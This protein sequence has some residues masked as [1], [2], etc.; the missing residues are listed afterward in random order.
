MGND[1]TDSPKKKK[2]VSGKTA[3]LLTAI[4]RLSKPRPN[5]EYI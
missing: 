3:R 5:L 4:E 1:T 2:R